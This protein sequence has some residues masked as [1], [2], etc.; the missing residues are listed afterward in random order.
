[1]SE[2][3]VSNKMKEAGAEVIER[4]R[5]VISSYALAEEVYNA[6]RQQEDTEHE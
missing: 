5:D 6:M 1:M 2:D 4:L 3:K